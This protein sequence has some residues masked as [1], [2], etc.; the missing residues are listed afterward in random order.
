MAERIKRWPTWGKVL[1]VV[2]ILYVLLVLGGVFMSG[3]EL[4]LGY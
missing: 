2:A 3:G 4:E 1:I